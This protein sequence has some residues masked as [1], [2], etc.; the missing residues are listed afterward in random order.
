M[1]KR[2]NDSDEKNRHLLVLGVLRSFGKIVNNE[3]DEEASDLFN[4]RRN[5]FPFL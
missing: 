5:V 4:P 3:I 1:A 2:T